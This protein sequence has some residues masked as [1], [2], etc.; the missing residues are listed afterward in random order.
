[1]AFPDSIATE[2]LFLSGRCCSLCRK[3]CGTRI[4]LHHI[5]QGGDDTLE[6][7]MPLCFD[8]HAD[9]KHYNPD[10]PRGRRFRPEELRK[11]RDK[12]YQLWSARPQPAQ[13]SPLD[14]SFDI[15]L[16][17][18]YRFGGGVDHGKESWLWHV[19]A[20]AYINPSLPQISIPLFRCR[21]ELRITGRRRPI[22]GTEIAF[23]ASP[24][25]GSP[26]DPIMLL[27]RAVHSPSQIVIREPGMVQLATVFETPVWKRRPQETAEVRFRLAVSQLQFAEFELLVRLESTPD[28]SRWKLST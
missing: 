13:A 24:Q 26:P 4:E 10:H 1:M 27:A 19:W 7:C 20:E 23:E 8:C 22:E 12:W 21:T 15:V 25:A 5:I 2:A 16:A 3:F 14:P 18:M 11:H 17:G 28:E 6:N 9:V